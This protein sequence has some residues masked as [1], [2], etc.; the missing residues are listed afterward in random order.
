M[1]RL[2]RDLGVDAQLI[3]M[4][5]RSIRNMIEGKGLD[6]ISTSL[7][8]IFIAGAAFDELVVIQAIKA[9]QK[10]GLLR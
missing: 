9:W 5:A 8:F 3:G 6:L 1:P 7:G 2:G 10:L 4:E